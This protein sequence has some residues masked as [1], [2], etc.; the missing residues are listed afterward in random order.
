[1]KAPQRPAQISD[2]PVR[3]E[4]EQLAF[5]EAALE[6]SLQA[7]ARAHV[8]SRDILVAGRRLRLHFAGEVLLREFMPALAHLAVASDETPGL[9][10]H[11]WDSESTGI[12]MVDPICK[13]ECFTHRGD[14]WS[15]HSERIRSAFH[16]VEGSV[17]LLDLDRG[18][19]I[20]WVPT[21]RSL[22]Y[23]AKASPLRTLFHWWMERV[24]CQLIHAAAVG[25][26]D[27]GL[28]ITGKGGLGK[29]TTALAC[30]AAGMTYLG[31][32]YVVVEL[33]PV[34]RAYS[35]YCTAK[36]NGDHLQRF[37][38]LRPLATNLDF[39]GEEKAVIRLYPAYAHQ[40]A[41]S[42]PL[43]A[44]L[45][46]RVSDSAGTTFEAIP[47][48]EL[49]GAGVF[50]T[51]S[52]LPH[53]G[54]RTHEFIDRLLAGLPGARIVLGRE[55]E[56][57]PAAVAG[58]L[59]MSDGA[60]AAISAAAVPPSAA[61]LPLVSVIVPVH[62]GAH[63]LAEAI[64]SIRGQ[65]YPVLEIIVV[66]DGSSDAIDEAVAGLPV[67]VRYFKQK[68]SGAS[69]AR[70]RGIRDASGDFIA[71][72]DVDDLWPAGMLAT[73]VNR[74]VERP[75]L[76]V[77]RGYAQLMSRNRPDSGFDYIGN[78]QESFPDYVGAGVYRREAFTKLGL[79]DETLQF[80]ED[81]DW[82][83][84][85]RERALAMERLD[86]VTLLVRRHGQNM[87]WQKTTAELE[88]LK[89]VKK[90]LDRL[91]AA[92]TAPPRD[93]KAAGSAEN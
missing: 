31:D 81:V 49:Q 77:V 79:F 78:P 17:N 26:G 70:N 19:A 85:A 52:Q 39:L 14:I 47:K 55:I 22:P 51:L 33:D 62:N 57:I 66:D 54:R 3:S 82:F 8:V 10:I 24:G 74:L 21:A 32:D 63:F 29:S 11:V 60:I 45:T 41:L 56:G 91:R 28:L 34:P 83:N 68:Q 13:R 42:I 64:R 75:E 37:P 86:R 6:R 16:W 4:A 20:Y 46:P 61:V 5:F 69:A 2:E 90:S 76:S 23:W 92:R 84:R 7:E 36:L 25:N 93:R 27:G 72:L 38:A 71:F 1:M 18:V 50:T 58:L 48:Q 30:L 43:R 40:I 65:S 53:A 89:A 73:L 44:V 35:L 9:E 15:L 80:S 12:A 67:D 88:A 87:T 59:A